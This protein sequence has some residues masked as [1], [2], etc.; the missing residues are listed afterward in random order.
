MT[1]GLINFEMI[2]YNT[3][4]NIFFQAISRNL[5]S[6]TPQNVTEF[7]IELLQMVV[8]NDSNSYHGVVNLTSQ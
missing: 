8:K 3:R 5:I 7:A 4:P 2:S 1:Q 6:L